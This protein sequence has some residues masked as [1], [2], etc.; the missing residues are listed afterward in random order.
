MSWTTPPCICWWTGRRV[1]TVS[2]MSRI[3]AGS[4]ISD[5]L[6]SRAYREA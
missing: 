4:L 2:T 3:G 1:A 6:S 5:L